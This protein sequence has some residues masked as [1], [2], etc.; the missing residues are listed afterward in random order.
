MNKI[1]DNC[2]LLADEIH[3]NIIVFHVREENNKSTKYPMSLLQNGQYLKNEWYNFLSGLKKKLNADIK[4]NYGENGEFE[5]LLLTTN[6]YVSLSTYHYNQRISRHTFTNCY[7]EKFF[8]ET[9]NYIIDDIPL[10][11]YL[12][13]KSDIKILKNIKKFLNKNIIKK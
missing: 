6:G 2:I 8:E 10:E 4:Y 13:N 5:T 1:S 9:I 3:P 11:D 12:K 7:F